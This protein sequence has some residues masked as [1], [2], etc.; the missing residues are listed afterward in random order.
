VNPI[1]EYNT[2]STESQLNAVDVPANAADNFDFWFGDD[3]GTE[4]MNKF[5]AASVA[6]RQTK[7]YFLP[8]QAF[9]DKFIA[10]VKDIY[11][12]DIYMMKLGLPEIFSP[13]D[14][15]EYEIQTEE[16]VMHTI[17]LLHQTSCFI[18]AL[19]SSS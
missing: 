18:H 11:R 8:K 12:Y 1:V 16:N 6:D 4:A 17:F 3:T 5:I 10:E 15:K 13:N 19:P 14:R 7:A 9:I 2:E